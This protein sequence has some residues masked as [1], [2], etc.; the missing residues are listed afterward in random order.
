MSYLFSN[1]NLKTELLFK[2]FPIVT[3]VKCDQYLKFSY[4]PGNCIVFF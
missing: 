2:N 3:C 1:K 4:A